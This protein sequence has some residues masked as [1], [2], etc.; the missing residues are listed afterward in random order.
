MRSTPMRACRSGSAR[1][2]GRGWL[3]SPSARGRSSPKTDCS[4]PDAAAGVWKSAMKCSRANP[5]STAWRSTDR[6]TSTVRATRPA[7]AR[8]SPA[9]RRGRRDRGGSVRQADSLDARAPRL[10]PAGDRWRTGDAAPVLRGRPRRRQLRDRHSIRAG[11]TARGSEFPVPRRARS[12]E[13]RA[14]D[15]VSPQRS[16]AGVAAVVFPVEQHS[17]RRAARRRRRAGSC[18]DPAV[19]EQQVRRMLADSAVETA[20]VEQLRR[21]VAAAAQHLGNVAPDADGVS[22]V[23]R[24]P[25]RGVPARNRAVRREPAARGSQ[26]GGAADART[27]RSSTSGWRATTRFPTSTATSSGGSRSTATSAAAACSARAAS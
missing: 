21:P 4:R 5:R 7:A 16:R 13:P 15:G 1:T 22:R 19:L 20:L 6:T 12:G 9:G 24:E 26:R 11:T 10:S 25:A 18:K 14:G 2:R 17:G 23:R 8:S 27:T 3:A